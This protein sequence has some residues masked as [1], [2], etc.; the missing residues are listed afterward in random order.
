M[1]QRCQSFR[2]LAVSLVICGAVF[3]PSCGKDKK[4]KTPVNP[5]VLSR[6]DVAPAEA[7]LQVGSRQQYKATAVF[8][9]DTTQDVTQAAYWDSSDANIASV[10]G[11]GTAEVWAE[12]MKAGTVTIT[13]T[14]DDKS[15]TATLIV[16]E[17]FIVSIEVQPATATVP[18]G[19]RQAFKAIGTYSDDSVIDVTGIAVWTS[20]NESVATFQGQEKGTA[21]S[22]A[23]G[24]AT[25]TATVDSIADTADLTVTEVALVSLEISPLNPIVAKGGALRFTATGIFS[26]D[27][28]QDLT[29]QSDWSSSDAGVASFQTPADKSLATAVGIGSATITV[30][31]DTFQDSTTMTVTKE[32]LKK[33]TVTPAGR[34]LPLGATL[35]FTATGEY[36]DAS[37][38]DVTAV[39]EWTSSAPDI[40][41]IDNEAGKK[42]QSKALQKGQ[43]TITAAVGA[44][45]GSTN[46][47][48][49]DATAVKITVTPPAPSIAA[50]ETVQFTATGEFSDGSTGDVTSRAA[51]ASSDSSV[52]APD[53][54]TK[55]LVKGKK[56][57]T[58]EI[59]ASLDGAQGSAVLTV[60]DAKLLSI[61]V[62]PKDKSLPIGVK[63]NYKAEGSYSDG[64]SRDITG[65]VIWSSTA[66][67]VASVSNAAGEKGRVTAL[68]LGT[69]RIAA[70]LGDASGDTGV[71]VTD[72]VLASIAV[73][74]KD[75]TIDIA[76]TLQFAAQGTYTDGASRDVTADATWDSSAEGVA[77][78]SSAAGSKGLAT[79]MNTGTTT[80]TATVGTVSDSTTLTV[81]GRALV[82]IRVD[83]ETASISK[84]KTKSFTAIG[85]YDDDGEQD[86]T[87]LVVWA[88]NNEAA[89]FVSNAEGSKGVVTG[90]EK[91]LATIS[92]TREGVTG[93]ASVTIIS[94][95]AAFVR[96]DPNED[97]K[98]DISDAVWVLNELFLS[99]E[100]VACRKACDCNA[101]GSIN[102]VDP[103]YCVEYQFL[104]GPLPPAPFPACGLEATETDLECPESKVCR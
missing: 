24:A 19:A 30:A 14:Y 65:N 88:S 86:L 23:P 84:G 104:H 96:C 27:S 75:Q 10:E 76:T 85:R 39:A 49:T 79:P 29:A 11:E 26:D 15:G 94:G 8:S 43:T 71:T 95:S 36:S 5:I 37:T 21:K 42:G 66:D 6:I 73:S 46:L 25:I 63:E 98:N 41:S 3:L 103:M 35:Q 72:V 90:L 47:T 45:Q 58:A 69:A 12:C 78:I 22:L 57:G 34:S 7:T 80:I 28:T 56:A 1:S 51:W 54:V 61:S 31:H 48:V 97:G 16:T 64:A 9:D 89:A 62:T 33:V 38:Q 59:T 40:A 67:T 17:P 91:G 53:A 70:A 60:T 99:G 50:S 101:D 102:L 32:T 81:K 87:T 83:P 55:G 52:A 68:A 92:A 77:T 93:T 74:P 82:S 2:I 44:I 20:S 18:A 4:K 100:R 13:A